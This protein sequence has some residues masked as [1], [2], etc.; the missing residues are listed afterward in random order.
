MKEYQRPLITTQICQELRMK[1]CLYSGKCNFITCIPYSPA[2]STL[3]LKSG[4][5]ENGTA[6]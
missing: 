2:P 5:N 4:I 3:L 6:Q 1:K